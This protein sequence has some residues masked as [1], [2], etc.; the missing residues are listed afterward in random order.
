MFLQVQ[1][2]VVEEQIP[3]EEK[4]T[5]EKDT[6]ELAGILGG[7]TMV[8]DANGNPTGEVIVNG[9]QETPID[10]VQ[11]A[12]DNVAKE[13]LRKLEDTKKE[14]INWLLTEHSSEWQKEI[15]EESLKMVKR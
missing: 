10:K 4:R 6:G 8:L 3:A 12:K 13:N 7:A 9:L 1:D 2:A 15:L 11:Q 5:S 14:T